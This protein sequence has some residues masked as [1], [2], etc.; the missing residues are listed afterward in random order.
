LSK[1]SC[2]IGNRFWIHPLTAPYPQIFPLSL[3]LQNK[4]RPFHLDEVVV[5]TQL[6]DWD[7]F[8]KNILS[9]IVCITN[10]VKFQMLVMDSQSFFYGFFVHMKRFFTKSDWLIREKSLIENICFLVGVQV[11]V[12]IFIQIA[13]GPYM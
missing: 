8:N 4:C 9:S 11:H 1:I 5:S 7:D 6:P 10:T 12:F 3:I 2:F 13:H